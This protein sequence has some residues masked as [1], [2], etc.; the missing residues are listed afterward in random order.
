MV[1][2]PLK[3]PIPTPAFGFHVIPGGML[4]LVT[5]SVVRTETLPVACTFT[6]LLSPTHKEDDSAEMQIFSLFAFWHASE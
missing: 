4:L 1:G 2:D 3:K 5:M 6:V